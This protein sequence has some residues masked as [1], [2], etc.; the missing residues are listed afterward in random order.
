M[1]LLGITQRVEIVTTYGERR[2]CLDQR[3][4][5]V[6]HSLGFVPIPLPNIPCDRIEKFLCKLDI[7]AILFSGGNSLTFLDDQASD[8]APERDQ[9]ESGLIEWAMNF[10][11]PVLGVCRGMQ[12]IN[13][14]FKGELKLV[15][16]HTDVRHVVTFS[17]ELSS[18]ASREVNSYHNWGI[19]YTGLGKGLQPLAQ[20]NDGTIEVFQHNSKRVAGMMWHPERESPLNP[21]DIRLMENFLL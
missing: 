14:F 3:W 11:V 15:Q 17:G 21:H 6:A 20:A 18:E 16:D 13:H 4:W 2:D 1:N 8:V 5:D 10:N 12:M 9:F 19:P 7:S